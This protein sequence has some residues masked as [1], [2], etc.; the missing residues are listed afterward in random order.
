MGLPARNVRRKNLGYGNKTQTV[1][2]VGLPHPDS[3]YR[4]SNFEWIHRT[5]DSRL[6]E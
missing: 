3:R 2:Q 6:T 1:V 5:V 4:G